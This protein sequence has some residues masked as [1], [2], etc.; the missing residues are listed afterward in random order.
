MLIPKRKQTYS[1]DCY[2]R[3]TWVDRRL[4]FPGN[5]SDTLALSISMLGRIWKPD[6]YFYNGKQSYLHT[7]TTP[8]K[9]VRLYQNGRVL[10]SSR[11][12]IKAGCPMNLEDFP[13]DIQRCPLKFGSFGYTSKDLVYK[14]NDIRQVAIAEDMKL[15]QFDLIATPAANRTDTLSNSDSHA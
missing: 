12:T 7:I 11:L 3:Q 2:F 8:N 4:A 13:M 15:S 10:Y 14:W 1:M 6:T 5:P 9:F